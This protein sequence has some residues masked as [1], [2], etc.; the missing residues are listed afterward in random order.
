MSEAVFAILGAALGVLGTFLTQWTAARNETLSDRRVVLRQ[1][2]VDFT[3]A[4]ARS[5][6][7][8]LDLRSNPEDGALWG[9]IDQALTDGRTSYERLRITA[10]SMEVQSAARYA[11][12]YAYRMART[13]Q[14]GGEGFEDAD[15]SYAAS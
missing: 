11:L 4:V 10:E 15:A 7:L 12:H 3:S 2:C 9:R 1:S 13:A 8:S 6:R 14:K 5:R